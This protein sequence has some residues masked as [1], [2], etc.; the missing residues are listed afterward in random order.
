MEL[1]IGC[2]GY[3]YRHWRGRWYPCELKASRW[4]GYYAEHF[5]TVE[6]N[7]SF[8]RFPTA[9][10]VRRWYRQAPT[11]FLYSVKAPRLITHLKRFH[12]TGRL[13]R[14]LYAVLADG[15]QDRL[16]CILFQLPPGLH[17]SQ[18]VLARMCDQLDPAFCN[19]CEFRHESWWRPEVRSFLAHTGAIFC[20]V[21]APAIPDDIIDTEGVLYL[22]LHGIPW[23]RQ[24]YTEAELS[25]LATR[26]R[27]ARIRQAWVY[28][29]NDA[30]A[31]AP[32]NALHLRELL[33]PDAG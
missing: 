7:A 5:D 28:F 16:G 29:N 31:F 25:A 22:R 24:N 2:S 4:F 26:I 13:V 3:Y 12:N 20:S 30:K 17:F 10:T 1:H 6:I 23:Y 11:G 15:L 21:H 32:A 9:S 33:H 14:D 19:V 27:T 18:E 8:Y